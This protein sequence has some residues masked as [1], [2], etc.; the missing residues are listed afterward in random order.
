[1]KSASCVW[2]AARCPAMPS[3]SEPVARLVESVANASRSGQPG[4]YS[5]PPPEPVWIKQVAV[6][7][8]RDNLFNLGVQ[9]NNLLPPVDSTEQRMPCLARSLLTR[10]QIAPPA[11]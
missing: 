2:A 7:G 1:M 4:F 5:V 8:N 3:A 6:K 11:A 10:L 9:E